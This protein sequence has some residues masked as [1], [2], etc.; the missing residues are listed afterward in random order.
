MARPS[1]E[2]YLFQ[3]VIKLYGDEYCSVFE[4]GDP[5]AF[6]APLF[7]ANLF[8]WIFISL[9]L[10]VGPKLIE[11]KALITVPLRFILLIIFVVK[12]AG[13]NSDVGGDGMN[14]YLSGKSFPLPAEEG[15]PE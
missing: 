10:A 6:A 5:S 8:C 15:E 4:E 14:W 1:E 9:S 13:L 11:V 2:I 7:F 12:F 3:N